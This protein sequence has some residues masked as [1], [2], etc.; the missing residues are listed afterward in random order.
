MAR[1]KRIV[2]LGGGTGT[3]TVLSGLKH[4]PFDLSAIVTVADNGGSSGVLRDEFGVLP[5]G[6]M[7]Q[8]IVALAKEDMLLRELFNY[9]FDR[10]SL[11]GHS[12]GN[13][14]LVA[15]EQLHGDFNKAMEAAHDLL[16]IRG[17]VIPITL[18]KV[19]LEAALRKGK[20]ISGVD[21]LSRS[22]AFS[23]GKVRSLSLSPQASINPKARRAIEEADALVIG[24]G[25]L[26]LSIVPLFLVKGVKEAVR[27]SKG[28][29]IYNCN[30]MT[31]RGHTD[32]FSVLDFA[33]VLES[34]LG[35]NVLDYVTFNTASPPAPLLRKYR[36]QGEQVSF[37]EL[38]RHCV[39]KGKAWKPKDQERPLFVGADLLN[40]K[41]IQQAKGDLLK[42]TFI[43]HH[44][45]KLAR[46]LSKII[47]KEL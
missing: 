27:K 44:P 31:Q 17:S 39:R 5:P 26:Y 34:Y 20:K 3:F 8:C 47:R 38:S 14:F 10:G 23:Q 6:D 25:N 37:K 24:P 41:E 4:L 28:V 1:R 2:C 13:L 45:H 42:R 33:R 7:R 29:K 22:D 19:H 35:E 30:V 43:R 40:K 11:K 46:F 32:H 12:F 21:E 16:R 18:E 36:A 9:R 15:L